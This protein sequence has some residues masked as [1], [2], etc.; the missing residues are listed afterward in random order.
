MMA[1]GKKKHEQKRQNIFSKCFLSVK[2]KME[3][4]NWK[5]DNSLHN[6]GINLVYSII[7][8]II[9]YM[10]SSGYNSCQQAVSVFNLVS[11]W[12]SL[13]FLYKLVESNFCNQFFMEKVY[14]ICQSK[15]VSDIFT[16]HTTHLHL[17]QVLKLGLKYQ[18]QKINLINCYN[19]AS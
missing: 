5:T 19:I 11:Y 6:Y 14:S 9:T 12:L 16:E 8:Y 2:M 10:I 15:S 13:L 17:N 1:G 3:L 4:K 7:S 18:N